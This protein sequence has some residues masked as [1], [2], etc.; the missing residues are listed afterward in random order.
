M[1]GWG[2][3]TQ[4]ARRESSSCCVRGREGRR[5]GREIRRVVLDVKGRGERGP[6]D[7]PFDAQ[8]YP[9]S[10]TGQ[11]HYGG[12]SACEKKK[13]RLIQIFPGDSGPWKQSEALR[14]AKWWR[15]RESPNLN[16]RGK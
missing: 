14:H 3:H 12:V 1:G 9:S 13:H 15:D 8:P 5:A 2:R 6:P 11:Q 16:E 7:A 10:L 4:K